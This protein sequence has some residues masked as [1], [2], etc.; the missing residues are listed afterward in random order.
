MKTKL[1]LVPNMC[2][3][4][5]CMDLLVANKLLILFDMSLNF[6]ILVLI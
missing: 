4:I 2:G 3:S 6:F 5:F 1:L